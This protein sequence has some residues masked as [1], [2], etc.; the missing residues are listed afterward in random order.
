P[1]NLSVGP[2]QGQITITAPGASPTTRVV[3]VRF[4]VAPADDPKLVTEPSRLDFERVQGVSTETYSLRVLNNGSGSIDFSVTATTTSG[5]TWLQ[6]SLANGAVTANA[7]VIVAITANPAGLA[8]G[9]YSGLVAIAATKLSQRV[10]VPVSL[11]INGSTQTIVLGQ[12]G[13]TFTAVAGG[14]APAS[15]SLGVLNP[16]LGTMNWTASADTTSRGNW[17]TPSPATGA[18]GPAGSNIGYIQVS[19]NPAGLGAGEYYGRIRVAAPDAANTPQTAAIVLRILPQG[20][21]PPPDVRPTGFIF[22][23]PADGSTPPTQSAQVTNLS[24]SPVTFISSS[25]GGFFRDQPANGTVAPGDPTTVR[26]EALP[27]GLSAGVRRGVITL[28]FSDGSIRPID[29]LLTIPPA[30]TAAS[31]AQSLPRAACLPRSLNP[32]FTLLGQQFV[33]PASWPV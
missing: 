28:Q 20:T 9:T 10:L 24:A 1:S 2:Y 12:T 13:L 22:V 7:P 21:Q 15:Q 31:M 18:S 27:A 17:L 14:S 8:P 30:G 19:V 26:I 4:D 32:V 3:P 16:G 25:T 6:A 29:V 23:A 11:T 33:V 5:S